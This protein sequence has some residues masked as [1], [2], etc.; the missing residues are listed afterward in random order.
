V[1]VEEITMVDFIGRPWVAVFED[2]RPSH[3]ELAAA[4][5]VGAAVQTSLCHAAI[6]IGMSDDTSSEVLFALYVRRPHALVGFTA[7][8]DLPSTAAALLKLAEE[9]VFPAFA[10]EDGIAA[11]YVWA[12][13]LD[14]DVRHLPV[15]A[16]GGDARAVVDVL[17]ARSG[18][19]P[20]GLL[21]RR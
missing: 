14:G 17:L 15:P 2:N 11:A 19:F 9:R 12:V 7:A 4:R 10:V 20:R 18:T 6:T 16:D 13:A 3:K 1:Q 21:S 8:G 5:H